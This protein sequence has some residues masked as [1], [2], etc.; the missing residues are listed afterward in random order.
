MSSPGS[1]ANTELPAVDEHIVAS[2]SGYEIDDGKLVRVVPSD[3][4]HGDR[5]A[6]ITALLEAHVADDFNVA[7]DML[8]R[9]S[10][11]DDFAPDASVYPRE[12]DP[13]TGGRQLEQLA[14]E[15]VSTE[16][17]GHAGRK[18][19]RLAERG[20][21][22]VFAIDVERQ[23]AFEWSRE[24]GT[25]SILESSAHIIDPSLAVPLPVEALARAANI[26]DAVAEALIA[27]RHPKIE[28]VCA[29][30]QSEGMDEG[31]ILGNIEGRLVGRIERTAEAILVVLASRGLPAGP[32]ERE[33][34]LG[35]RDP[36]RLERWL[37]RV[38]LCASVADLLAM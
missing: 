8:T 25:W 19:G 22:R 4:P 3:E 15:V 23:R 5:H 37:S 11:T 27:R 38:A 32:E 14:F 35:E 24:L 34:I 6:K 30:A 16:T 2:E 33:R 1:N 18:A 31:R 28:D 7:I 17:L 9:T 12:R 29:R 26:D 10:E 20:V 13:E 36:D 21:R